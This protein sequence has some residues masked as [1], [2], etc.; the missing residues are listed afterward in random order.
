MNPFQK[1]A[2]EVLQVFKDALPKVVYVELMDRISDE[3]ER[4]K[5]EGRSEATNNA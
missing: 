2:E 1:K 4:A 3:L 5:N